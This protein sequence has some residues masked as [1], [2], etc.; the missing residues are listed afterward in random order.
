MTT[1]VFDLNLF[2]LINGLAGTNQ[3]LDFVAVFAAKW[4]IYFLVAVVI[5][6]VLTAWRGLDEG[7]RSEC[8]ADGLVIGMRSMVTVLSC[9]IDSLVMTLVLFRPRPFVSLDGVN[10]LIDPPLLAKVLSFRPHDSRFRLG[11]FH[12]D[13]QSSARHSG[14]DGGRSCRSGPYLRRRSLS[15]R[16]AGRCRIGNV[17]GGGRGRRREEFR[18]SRPTAAVAAQK[19]TFFD[20]ST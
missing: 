19:A 8:R 5:W 12:T 17:L 9:A 6:L 4:L 18:R 3:V 13:G 15:G 10:L 20:E 16:R 1:S 2:R 11:R 7:G 14:F